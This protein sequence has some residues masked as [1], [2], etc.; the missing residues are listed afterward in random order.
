MTFSDAFSTH[1]CDTIAISIALDI[2][3]HE[4]DRLINEKLNKRY[5]N[6]INDQRR[7]A[8]L[9]EIRARCQA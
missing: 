3:E 4:A 7:R 8:A 9:R 6:R 2:P 1:G 5:E